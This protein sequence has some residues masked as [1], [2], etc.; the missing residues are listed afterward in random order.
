MR[1][2]LSQFSSPTT[3]T[4]L[5][6]TAQSSGSTE[7]A[8]ARAKRNSRRSTAL[9][10]T[11]LPNTPRFP[12]HHTPNVEPVSPPLNPTLGTHRLQRSHSTRSSNRASRLFL[13]LPPHTIRPLTLSDT[14]S[15]QTPATR[16]IGD[17]H[18]DY[19][20]SRESR[21]SGIEIPC[22]VCEMESCQC[23]EII[24]PLSGG[25]HSAAKAKPQNHPD[26]KAKIDL[27][28]DRSSTRGPTTRR[29]RHQPNLRVKTTGRGIV[30]APTTGNLSFPITERPFSPQ[31]FKQRVMR[32]QE[33]KG[34]LDDTLDR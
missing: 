17:N 19:D 15:P 27:T 11:S 7:L 24:L 4:P 10:S 5:P 20:C 3:H 9:Y 6:L 34:V 12:T 14:P 2:C 32:K 22:E 21:D 30:S 33:S 16:S 25:K 31:S 26:P 8:A 23:R 29:L 18:S 1:N 28:D 13:T